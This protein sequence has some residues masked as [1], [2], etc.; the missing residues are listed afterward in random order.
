MHEIDDETAATKDCA[1]CGG[2]AF[3]WRSAIMAGNPSAPGWRN[4][5]PGNRQPAWTCMNCGYIQ[6]HERRTISRTA[7]G[8]PD[9][10]A[11]R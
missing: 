9:L 5:A 10:R 11:G 4:S 7:T 8:R 2:R 6:P 3:Y 1:R